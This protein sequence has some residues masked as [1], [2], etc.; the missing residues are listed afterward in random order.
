MDARN[1]AGELAKQANWQ[2]VGPVR[3]I[4]VNRT[5]DEAAQ[6]GDLVGHRCNEFA[7]SMA[8][9]AVVWLGKEKEEVETARLDEVR[10]TL[11]WMATVFGLIRFPLN[12]ELK[13]LP[14]ASNKRAERHIWR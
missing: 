13:K 5:K 6:A 8:K 10:R 12:S 9:R 1:P 7:D 4:K 2:N 14:G 11:R 3:K